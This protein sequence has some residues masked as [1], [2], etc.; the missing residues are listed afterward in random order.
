M[1]DIFTKDK[2]SDIMSRIHSK[3]TSPEIRVRKYLYAHGFRY[4][5]HKKDL[6]GKPDLVLSKYKMA[7]FVNGCFWHGHDCKIGS[8]SRR[9][10]VNYEYW[11]RKIEG[12]MQRDRQHDIQLKEQGWDTLIVWECQ[13]SSEASLHQS[14]APLLSRAEVNL[15]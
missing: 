12:N 5:L 14:L 7:V 3:D 10:Q 4:R 9:P 6:P 15:G 8:G 11:N 13:T 1:A 2:R